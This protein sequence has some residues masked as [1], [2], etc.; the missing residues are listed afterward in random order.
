MSTD[1]QVTPQEQAAILALRQKQAD[2]QAAAVA[3]ATPPPPLAAGDQASTLDK[4]TAVEQ[5]LL[6]LL[7]AG[8]GE[9]GAAIAA[10]AS[11]ATNLFTLFW[12][13]HDKHTGHTSDHLTIGDAHQAAV[14]QMHTYHPAVLDSITNPTCIEITPVIKVGVAQVNA[15]PT[16]VLPAPADN[17]SKSN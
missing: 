15:Q 14:V 4:V 3:A 8:F 7:A 12:R 6:P 1:F 16:P 11:L 13:M 5:Q 9:T 10:G 17:N 2:A